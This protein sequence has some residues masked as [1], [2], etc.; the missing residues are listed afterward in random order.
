M[1]SI[2]IEKT[3][4]VII[5]NFVYLVLKEGGEDEEVKAFI[6]CKIQEKYKVFCEFIL[7]E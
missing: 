2:A 4:I 7:Q 5:W 6:G 1:N 3:N